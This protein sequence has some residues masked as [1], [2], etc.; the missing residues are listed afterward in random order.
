MGYLFEKRYK[1]EEK[2]SQGFFGEIYNGF[3]NKLNQRVTIKTLEKYKNPILSESEFLY[4]EY[5]LKYQHILS[6][7]NLIK[8]QNVFVEN[9]KMFII[10][11][12]FKAIDLFEYIKENGQL[13][14]NL[15]IKIMKG[16]ING[17]NQLH[18]MG[19][20]HRDLKLEN[21]L[22]NDKGEIKIIDFGL[23]CFKK[24][25]SLYDKI[26]GTIY[27]ISPEISGYNLS[28]FNYETNDIWGIGII[29]YILIFHYYPFMESGNE[30]SDVSIIQ[31]KIRR[32]IKYQKPIIKLNDSDYDNEVK[33]LIREI[34]LGILNKNNYLRYNLEDI[35]NSLENLELLYNNSLKQEND[36]KKEKKGWSY[37]L[38]HLKNILL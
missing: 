8:Y 5:V 24:S 31:E 22:I 30:N 7:E 4:C 11:E 17:I 18:Y 1:I 10:M 16:I 12:Y 27:Y 6:F 34:L 38:N 14:L 36:E 15:V 2:I 3:D 9:G 28:Y 13:E 35:E 32:K 21:I 26:V 33:K 20:C 19:I 29:F 25:T 37:Y 23:S